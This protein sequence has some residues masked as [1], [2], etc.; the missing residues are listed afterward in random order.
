MRWLKKIR[1]QIFTPAFLVNSVPKAG[2]NLLAKAVLLLPG[3]NSGKLHLGYSTAERYKS[4]ESLGLTMP[5]GIDWPRP[6][7]LNGV[8]K[9]ARQLP[10][11]CFA[12]AHLPF[13]PEANNL[14][15]DLQIKSLLILRDPRDVVVSHANYIAH[16]PAHFL[17]AS[18]ANLAPAERIMKSIVG[19]DPGAAEGPTLLNI[20]ERYQQ[21]IPWGLQASN[22]TTS[23]EKLVGPAGGGSRE[24]QIMELRAIAQHLDIDCSE[25]DIIR[26]AEQLFGGTPTFRK[27]IIGGWQGIFSN[28]HRRSFKSLAGQ[29]LI[30]LKYEHDYNW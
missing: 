18:Y 26:V 23:F 15:T 3:I 12:T 5:M 27:G 21:V 7:S 14:L 19:L 1:N 30:D 24:V 4:S 13:S 6:V 11:G 29:L 17:Y 9:I 10:K 8:R 20:Y 16:N 2:T 25:N 28:E 22:Y